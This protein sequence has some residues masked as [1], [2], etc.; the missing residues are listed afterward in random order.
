MLKSLS[1]IFVITN[2]LFHSNE[3]HFN[4]SKLTL[5]NDTI[6]WSGN[7]RL[8]WD[9]FKGEI[10]KNTPFSVKAQTQSGIYV[11]EIR[12]KGKVPKYKIETYFLKMVS[13]T[14]VKDEKILMHEQL[15]FDISELYARKLRKSFDS[16]KVRNVIDRNI[17]KDFYNSNF[18]KLNEYQDQY[19]KE[20]YFD[21]IAQEEWTEKIA[22]ELY[23]LSKYEMP[24]K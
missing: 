24:N 4:D 11:E 8:V 17:Y 9:D 14:K 21:E 10:P 12:V 23:Y 15:H 1:C 7:Y 19:D 2:L 22:T 6:A 5:K 18:I 3:V 16:L 13:W 20:V